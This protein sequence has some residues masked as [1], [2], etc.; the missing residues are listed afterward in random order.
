MEVLTILI[1]LLL[2]TETQLAVQ[3]LPSYHI[4][5]HWTK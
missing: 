4:L 2:S 5:L 3:Q 1:S